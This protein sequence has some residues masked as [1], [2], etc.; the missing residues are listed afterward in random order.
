MIALISIINI[1]PQGERKIYV[2]KGG[3]LK[4]SNAESERM[5]MAVDNILLEHSAPC[6]CGE[7]CLNVSEFRRRKNM[8][9][10]A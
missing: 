2:N 10:N 8:L 7:E 4:E 5:S 3:D 6:F 9:P 1:S